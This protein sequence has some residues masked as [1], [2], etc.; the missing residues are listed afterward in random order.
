VLREKYASA[1]NLAASAGGR[2]DSVVVII[3]ECGAIPPAAP[4]SSGYQKGVG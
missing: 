3:L 4:Q 1:Q 2:F